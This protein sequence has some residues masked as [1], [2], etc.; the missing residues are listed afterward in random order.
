MLNQGFPALSEVVD[1]AQLRA[2][3]SG[4][5]ARNSV[6][7][8]R[9]GVFPRNPA[10]LISG[11]A[12]LAYAVAPFEGFVL[13]DGDP[14]FISL[15]GSE[16]VA[17]DPP[18]ASNSRID[19][20]CVRQG[21]SAP[22]LFVVKGTAA[23]NPN[24]P[25][26]PAD[27]I[28]LG[29]AQMTSGSTNTNGLTFI[30]SARFTTTSGGTM[31]VLNATDLASW[32]P[33]DGNRAYRLDTGTEHIRRG[34]QWVSAI[35]TPTRYPVSAFTVAGGWSA[36]AR[37]YVD[38]D[39]DRGV[40]SGVIHVTK[41]TDLAANAN[42]LAIRL[43][44]A[45]YPIDPVLYPCSSSGTSSP[46]AAVVEIVANGQIT[47]FNTPAAHRTFSFHFEYRIAG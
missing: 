16:S 4:L 47:V 19:I 21:P 40:A 7:A 25:A 29:S 31:P 17:T 11:T 39:L 28:E 46:A 37:T 15:R 43:P 34:G 38:V 6:G 23:A 24:R 30:S 1:A 45:A 13:I 10:P 20:V 26:V 22:E 8:P 12:G 41:D 35:R 3:L 9:S 18:P 2:N 36:S 33:M 44:A 5:V 27:A 42:Q 32:T 14:V